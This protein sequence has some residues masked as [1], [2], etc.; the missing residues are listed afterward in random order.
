MFSTNLR[1]FFCPSYL[2][3]ATELAC[4][5]G[6]AFDPSL[7]D[8]FPCR[9]TRGNSD[10]C[11]SATCTGGTSQVLR[12]PSLNNAAMGQIG[13]HCIGSLSFVYRCGPNTQFRVENS[14]PTCAP[15]T[16]S[17][18]GQRF[19]D[20]R[21]PAKYNVCTLNLAGNSYIIRSFNCPKNHYFDAKKNE[22]VQDFASIN[23]LLD[24]ICP[25]D[26]APAAPLSCPARV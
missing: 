15:A 11:I 21:N 19:S 7:S 5:E 9:F 26:V 6:Y 24:T 18:D 16:C 22:C 20:V 17:N 2:G 3:E 14:R 13:V 1:Y 10:T 25:L 4:P 8:A 23:Q 12:Y